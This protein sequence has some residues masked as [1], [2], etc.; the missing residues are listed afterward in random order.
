[1]SKAVRV[2]PAELREAVLEHFRN[3]E[4]RLSEA[5][6]AAESATAPELAEA[7]A[8]VVAPPERESAPPPVPVDPGSPPRCVVPLRNGR[9]CARPGV[10][11]DP[12]TGR[13][14]CLYHVHA[15]GDVS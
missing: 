5:Q 6:V 4:L 10:I 7:A 12:Q 3:R 15:L 13:Y 9:E 8:D 1:M 2:T 11:A 14:R